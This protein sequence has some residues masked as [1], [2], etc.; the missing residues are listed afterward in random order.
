M[1]LAEEVAALKLDVPVYAIGG[2]TLECLEDLKKAGV[3]RIA[4]SQAV[5][6]STNPEEEARKFVEVM[7]A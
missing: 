7:N 4:L 6:G 3:T 5:L 1:K 2:I